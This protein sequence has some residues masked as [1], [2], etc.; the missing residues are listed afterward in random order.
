MSLSQDTRRPLYEIQG[1][2]SF[3][4]HFR[5]EPPPQVALHACHDLS[6]WLRGSDDRIAALRERYGHDADVELVEVSCL[7]RCDN[8]PALA[9]NDVPGHVD[10][11]DDLVAR[12]RI[13]SAEE[14]PPERHFPFPAGT[15][16]LK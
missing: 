11:A 8:A 4:P 9:V 5:T 13:R 7:G 1:L 3:Y 14:E 6:C 10:D 16:R 15:L 12:A 2:V